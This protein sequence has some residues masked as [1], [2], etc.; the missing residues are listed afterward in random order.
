LDGRDENSLNRG[1]RLKLDGVFFEYIL[2]YISVGG[3]FSEGEAMP[4]ETIHVK[5]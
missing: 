2:T 4:C 1:G 3:N 5:D